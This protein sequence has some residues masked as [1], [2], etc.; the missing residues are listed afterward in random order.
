MLEGVVGFLELLYLVLAWR[1]ALPVALALLVAIFGLGF[2]GDERWH[3]IL[4]CCLVLLA[5]VAGAC[6][7]WGY[8]RTQRR[9]RA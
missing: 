9:Q 7:Q 4:G 2:L 1:F 5:A 6:W 8:W 3:V